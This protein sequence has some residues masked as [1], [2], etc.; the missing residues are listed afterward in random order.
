M[1]V[2]RKSKRFVVETLGVTTNLLVSLV[3]LLSPP[4]GLLLAFL[5]V[6]LLALR[7]P[8]HCACHT[9]FQASSDQNRRCGEAREDNNKSRQSLHQHCYLKSQCSSSNKRKISNR[10][11]SHTMSMPCF[12]DDNCLGNLLSIVDHG[13]TKSLSYHAEHH[14]QTPVG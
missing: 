6:F 1:V 10:S 2:T 7:L 11:S 9:S 3:M 5:L 13:A 4:S 8:C 12:I 14:D